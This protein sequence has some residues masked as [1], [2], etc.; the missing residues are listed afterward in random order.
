[1]ARS[2]AGSP[3]AVRSSGAVDSCFAAH[4][5]RALRRR[6]V[7]H[8]PR[9]RRCGACR[10]R[11][12]VVHLRGR[13]PSAVPGGAARRIARAADARAATSSP[14]RR[15]RPTRSP[16]RMPTP[17]PPCSPRPASPPPMSLAAG[18]HGQ[19]VRHCPEEGWTLQLNNAA[20]VAERAGRDGRRRLSQPR[21]R[22]RRTG[23]AARSRVSRGAVRARR[24]RPRR[25]QH[26][27][28]RQSHGLCRRAAISPP[29]AVSTPAPATC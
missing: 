7:R 4:A 26:R 1:M 13:R 8:E 15:A 22:R 28:H 19:T 21:R 27:R 17:L 23:R 12:R 9:R 5:R 20:R 3:L 6:D 14:A 16:T 10:F 29:C 24:R 2:F 25:R 11:R 18:V